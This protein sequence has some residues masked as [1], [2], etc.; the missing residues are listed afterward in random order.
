MGTLTLIFELSFQLT[1][2]KKYTERT[3]MCNGITLKNR[4]WATDAKLSEPQN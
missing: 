4:K 1:L 3:W 2:I